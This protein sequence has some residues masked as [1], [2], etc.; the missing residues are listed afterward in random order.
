[1]NL[2]FREEDAA[3]RREVLRVHLAVLVERQVLPDEAQKIV[4]Q[5]VAELLRRHHLSNALLEDDAHIRDAVIVPEDEADLRRGMAFLRELHDQHLDFLGLEREPH[6]PFL[7]VGLLRARL[8]VRA[9]MHSCH[10]FLPVIELMGELLSSIRQPE[11][12]YLSNGKRERKG[13]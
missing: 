10:S 12:P 11:P 5:L 1:V 13:I 9:A 2:R 7:A 6:M 4:G 3:L 8:P